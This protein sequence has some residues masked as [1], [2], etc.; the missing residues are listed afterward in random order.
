M[1]STQYLTVLKAVLL[2]VP[3]GLYFSSSSIVH[4]GDRS[5]LSL[6][7]VRPRQ[8]LEYR[9]ELPQGYLKVYSVTDPFDDG[10]LL[11]YAHSSYAIYTI[12]GKLFKRVENHISRSDELP[13][14]VSLPVG[15]YIVEARSEKDGYIRRP[16]TIKEGRR[17]ILDLDRG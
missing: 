17:T 14:M 2:M 15:S 10:G 7:L 4:A 11:Y 5:A 13:E 6:G 3:V 9:A 16:V 1:H 12:N 8:H